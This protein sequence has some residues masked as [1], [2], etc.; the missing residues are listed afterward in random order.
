M[1]AA[2]RIFAILIGLSPV[3]MVFGRGVLGLVLLATLVSAI[4]ALRPGFIDTVRAVFARIVP[5]VWPL[6]IMLAFWALSSA[7]SDDPSAAFEV[8]IR[9]PFLFAALFLILCAST[10]P[11]YDPRLTAT[12]VIWGVIAASLIGI[13]AETV[14]YDIL[15]ILRPDHIGRTISPVVLLAFK[16]SLALSI[17]VLVWWG[18][19]GHRMAWVAAALALA[20]IFGTEKFRGNAGLAGIL[21]A[22]LVVALV[23]LATRIPKRGKAIVFSTA[24]IGAFGVLALFAWNLPEYP[25]PVGFEDNLP[26]PFIDA[27]RQAIW[28]FTWEQIGDH[29]WFGY[30]IDQIKNAPGAAVDVPWLFQ[31]YLPA[32]PHNWILEITAETGLFGLGAMVFWLGVCSFLLVRLCFAANVDQRRAATCIV[33]VMAA[34][35]CSSL[36]NFSAFSTWWNATGLLH[37]VFPGAVLLR[38]LMAEGSAARA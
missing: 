28:A 13:W 22:V 6:L 34:Y 29:P 23:M 16:S 35:W 27:H 14:D 9:Y 19:T 37:L 30:G 7:L 31:A 10:H 18:V 20:L 32:H 5:T 26:L 8:L 25:V 12:L 2:H 11:G 33:A 15:Y 24:I 36:F 21:G 17:P 3:V 38:S 4:W 1:T